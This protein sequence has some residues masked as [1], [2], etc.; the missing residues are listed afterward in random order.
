MNRIF[1]LFA[2]L[3]LGMLTLQASDYDPLAKQAA[4]VTLG[5]VRFTV[6][7]E[8]MIRME[9]SE[10]AVFKDNASLIVVNRDL[11]VPMFTVRDSVNGWLVINTAYLHLSYL[12]NSGNFSK[13]NLKIVYQD[14]SQK[15]SWHYGEKDKRNLKGTTRTLDGVSG[16]FR[17][18]KVSRIR[19][20][21]G[22]LSRNGWTLIND[23]GKPVFDHSDWPWVEPDSSK[24]TDLYFLGYGRH[25]REAL[26][27]YT[28]IAG[29]IPMPPKFAFGVWY[30]KW[31]NYTDEQY[32]SIVEG[33]K[34]HN[35][36]LDVLVLDMDW[37]ITERS[38]PEL[39]PGEKKK[40]LNPNGWTGF[41]WE[42]KYFPDY[43]GFLA[44]TNEHHIQTC[45]NLHPANG[46]QSYECQYA[47]FAKAMHADTSGR[48]PI[49]FDIT[50]KLF[51]KNYFDILLHPY[52]KA[53]VDF[54]WLDWQQW[55]TT[56]IKGL[57]PTFYLNYLHYS[58]QQREGKRPLIFHRWGG[59]GNHR[60]EIGFS[61]DVIINWRS[62][63]LQ[64]WFTSTA[65]NVGFGYWSHDIGGHFG[66]LPEKKKD[67]Q[68]FL[69]WVQW[70][71]FSPIFRTH[72]TK[73]PRIE[74][75][76][77]KYPEPYRSAMIK[78]VQERYALFP[79][80]YTN[81]RYA[82]DSGISIL[83]PMYYDHPELKKAYKL[84][85]QYYFGEN[86]IV[87]PLMKKSKSGMVSAK[88]WLPEGAWYRYDSDVLIKGGRN[89]TATYA[90]NEVPVFV[91]AGSIIPAQTA[92]LNMSESVLD[93]LILSVYPD[94]SG[95]GSF[96][97]YEDDGRTDNYQNGEYSLTAFHYDA[98]GD[99]AVFRILPDGR[100]LPGRVERRVYLIRLMRSSQPKAITEE[101]GNPFIA[102]KY[103]EASGTTL[104]YCSRET[105]K[106]QV[107][108]IAF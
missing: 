82:Y 98:S 103:D 36:P 90:L 8:R 57:N 63:R 60:Y 72:S 41:T 65:S 96:I 51:A 29:K 48:K 21:D 1:I 27:D 9:Y 44:W 69:R 28:Q 34:E 89:Y 104:I 32:K 13:K 106:T 88:V 30:S 17:I 84:P 68:L 6:L 91:K 18:Y 92:K 54:W 101:G 56:G 47:D 76:I 102:W 25:Y 38:S 80:I 99:H 61:G 74:R 12:K 71:A 33:Y 45:L 55:G 4:M 87:A 108:H 93:T 97:L 73:D 85:N 105:N 49:K 37:H 23:S 58:D 3:L 20:E 2:F 53:G 14:G 78:A 70:G 26:L 39:F 95:R 40:L 10:D 7:S 24:E 35:I 79:Y 75:C 62:L 46:V 86:M 50:N 77:W 67:P 15:Y 100:I 42:K 94:D 16:K 64:P 11:P 83:H 22:I 66:I 5:K 19:L 43:K 59:L 52:E 81:A 107:L 31:W